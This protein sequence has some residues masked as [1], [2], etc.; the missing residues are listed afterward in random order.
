MS[1]VNIKNLPLM[2]VQ[3]LENL[4]EHQQQA[5]F[6]EYKRKEKS[7]VVA[8]L[9]WLISCHYIYVGKIG[10]FFIYLITFAGFLI[11]GFIDLF[12]MPGIV[13]D[14][15]KDVATEILKNL[16]LVSS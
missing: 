2:V 15:N 1:K 12:R 3:Q 14:Y 8:Y 6:E 16:K 11:W 7:L 4:P 5:F 10:T 9:L 13:R